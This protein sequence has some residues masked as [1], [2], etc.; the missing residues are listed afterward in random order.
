LR[1]LTIVIPTY[2]EAENLQAL[3]QALW[4]LNLP[5]LKVVVVDDNSPDGTGEIAADLAR[6]HPG[7]VQVIHR[8]GKLGLGSAYITGFQAALEQGAQAVGQMDAD[9]SHSP[10]YIPGFLETLEQADAVFGSRYVPGGR[11]DER[12]GKGR[13][14]L[15]AFG[16][17]YARTIL[18]LG[19]RDATGGFRIWRGETLAS[20]PLERIRSNG[21]VFQVEMAFVAQRLGFRIVEKPIYFID[22]RIGQSK[23]SFRIQV[24]AAVRVWQLPWLHRGLKPLGPSSEKAL[25]A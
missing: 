15:S 5:N 21:Y 3:L 7:R 11:L 14:F 18:R 8:P 9:F 24:E 4:A 22:R 20:L 19:V 12:W 2:N 17:W 25:K 13:L 10:E 6:Q 1:Q 23:M 16:N